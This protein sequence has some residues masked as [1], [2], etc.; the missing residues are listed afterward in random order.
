MQEACHD[1]PLHVFDAQPVMGKRITVMNLQIETDSVL[2]L[3]L[4][5]FTWPWRTRAALRRDELR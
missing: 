3:V 2:S 5:G 4:T 1:L